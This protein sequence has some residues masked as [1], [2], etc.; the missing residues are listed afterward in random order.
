MASC[1]TNVP[2]SSAVEITVAG[3]K[4]S[5]LDIA[6]FDRD[7]SGSLQDKNA[8]VE[9]NEIKVLVESSNEL[10]SRSS[11]AALSFIG[12]SIASVNGFTK[13]SSEQIYKGRCFCQPLRTN[14]VTGELTQ[15]AADF[16][17]E[18]LPVLR[19]LKIA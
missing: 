13:F 12:A 11:F 3:A 17:A 4:L 2:L 16:Q 5:F 19:R 1:A 8:V 15:M 7:L 6:K 10:I 18:A 14:L 9:A